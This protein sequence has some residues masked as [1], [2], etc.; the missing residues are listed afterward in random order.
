MEFGNQ[1]GPQ[2]RYICSYIQ[3]KSKILEGYSH[4]HTTPQRIPMGNHKLEQCQPRVNIISPIML[5]AAIVETHRQHVGVGVA[6]SLNV[7]IRTTR[8]EMIVMPNINVVKRGVLIGS[9]A[10]LGS[11]SCG[12][13][14]RR[15]LSQSSA[16][17]IA[18]TKVVGISQMVFTNPIMVIHGNKTTNRP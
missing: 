13:S 15:N 5:E 12:V 9:V 14:A 1:L 10:K 16:L 7:G 4:P 18:I 8:V 2:S 3:T 17:P 11:E 6:Q